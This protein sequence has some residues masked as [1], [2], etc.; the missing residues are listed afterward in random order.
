MQ[1]RA[2]NHYQTDSVEGSKQNEGRQIPH[3]SHI[4]SICYDILQQICHRIAGPHITRQLLA[5]VLPED[6]QAEIKEDDHA[7][8]QTDAAN[9]VV[10]EIEMLVLYDQLKRP[11]HANVQ[12]SYDNEAKFNSK[13]WKYQNPKCSN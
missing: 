12:G 11:Q 13:L 2:Y 4:I 9:D 8:S 7:P 5:H 10:D 3:L 1:L 6:E